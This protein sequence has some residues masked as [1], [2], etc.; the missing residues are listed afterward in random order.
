MDDMSEEVTDANGNNRTDAPDLREFYVRRVN[1]LIT[2]GRSDLIDEIADD[3]ERRSSSHSCADAT[4]AHS[5]PNPVERG[6]KAA[7]SML[8]HSAKP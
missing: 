1:W 3:C 5:R 4:D 7:L 2:T 6:T 8:R